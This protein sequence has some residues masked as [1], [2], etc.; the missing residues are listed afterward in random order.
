MLKSQN[1]SASQK[2]EVGVENMGCSMISHICSI[3]IWLQRENQGGSEMIAKCIVNIY[4]NN[5]TDTVILHAY[6][7]R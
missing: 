2:L 4:N 3:T 5:Q 6:K 7:M 1:T